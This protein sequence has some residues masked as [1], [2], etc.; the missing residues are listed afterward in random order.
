MIE[1]AKSDAKAEGDRIVAA[2][3]AEIE[4]EVARAKEQLREQVAALAVA[5]AEKILRREVDAKAH[6][7]LLAESEERAEVAPWPNS[8]RS[9]ALRRSGLQARRRRRTRCRVVEMLTLGALRSR[10][11]PADRRR[12]SATRSVDA[13]TQL[14]GVFARRIAAIVPKRGAATS[15]RVLVE[16]GRLALLP[17][18]RELFEA[19]KNEREG[20]VDAEIDDAR[21]PLDDA[22]L[23]ALVPR[24][25]QRFKRKDRAA[26][27][28]STRR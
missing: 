7:D 27:R 4:Q 2:A 17:E 20:V 3:K 26:R 5:G 18:I 10:A 19:L 9:R 16:N 1:E 24:S 23:A 21:S 13:P 15:L 25:K 11:N 12:S 6:A 8:P 14:D 28:R 22:Q